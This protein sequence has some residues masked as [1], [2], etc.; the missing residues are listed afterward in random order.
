MGLGGSGEH[1]KGEMA[2]I[3]ESASS[4]SLRVPSGK[5]QI[6]VRGLYHSELLAS[7]ESMA[8]LPKPEGDLAGLG[9]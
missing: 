2:N 6:H 7:E 1:R 5:A 3:L 9:N 4:V 8:R